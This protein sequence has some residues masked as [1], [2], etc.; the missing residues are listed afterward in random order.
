[1]TVVFQDTI[2]L[3][4]KS[5]SYFNRIFEGIQSGEIRVARRLSET[6]RLKYNERGS[7]EGEIKKKTDIERRGTSEIESAREKFEGG[8]KVGR[9]EE[10]KKR[11]CK[12]GG[13]RCRAN[14]RRL[15][16]VHYTLGDVII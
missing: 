1:M 14:Q 8:K 9:S 6:E 11:D 16:V 12:I 10:M 4:S 2:T 15:I 5:T 7:T 13:S 3:G